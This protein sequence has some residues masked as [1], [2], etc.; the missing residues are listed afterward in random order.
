MEILW[1]STKHRT[2]I[3]CVNL[4]NWNHGTKLITCTLW[5]SVIHSSTQC[6]KKTC[7]I[8]SMC[9]TAETP[10]IIIVLSLT[11]QVSLRDS[12][13]SHL[14]FI[15]PHACLWSC[16]IPN[17]NCLFFFTYYFL[18]LFMHSCACCFVT[19]PPEYYKLR[20]HEPM[21][22]FQCSIIVELM[23]I[24]MFLFYDCVIMYWEIFW[25]R[26]DLILLTP[27]LWSSIFILQSV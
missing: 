15:S 3:T 1:C 9:S 27:D 26:W 18:L 7:V 19:T 25:M 16:Q 2:R 8:P 10:S 21:L 14:I 11:L 17:Q 12:S 24:F 13:S 4:W 20:M 6:L 22:C 23:L 5:R